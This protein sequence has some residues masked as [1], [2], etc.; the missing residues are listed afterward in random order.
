MK[1]RYASPVFTYLDFLHLDEA[2]VVA[3]RKE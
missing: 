1:K 2:P 3:A